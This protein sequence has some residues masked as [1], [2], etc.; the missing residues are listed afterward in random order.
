[1]VTDDRIGRIAGYDVLSF[2]EDINCT[3]MQFR[4][5]R[6]WVRHPKAKLS[7]YTMARALNTSAISLRDAITNLVENGILTAQHNNH[8]LTTYA[9]SE[10]GAQ[11]YIDELGSLDIHQTKTLE[12]QLKEKTVSPTSKSK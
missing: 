8:G 12:R 2:L 1:M 9:L 4:L 7:L 6:F 5:L 10:Q 11:E 3:G